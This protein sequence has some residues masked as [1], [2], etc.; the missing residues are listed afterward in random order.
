MQ[1]RNESWTGGR[2]GQRE[3]KGAKGREREERRN[4]GR[5]KTRFLKLT[6]ARCDEVL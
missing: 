2:E 6:N 1:S 5:D 4:G 3:A